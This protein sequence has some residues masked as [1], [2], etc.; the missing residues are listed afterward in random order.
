MTA[1]QSKYRLPSE[2]MMMEITPAIAGDWLETRNHPKNRKPSKTVAVRYASDM[3]GGLYRETPEPMIFDTDGLI[4]SAQHRLWAVCL[5]GTTQRFFVHPNQ[6]R[7]IFDSIDQGWKRSA[8]QVMSMPNATTVAAGARY[9]ATLDT[10]PR[11]FS[12]FTRV[13]NPEIAA[14]VKRWPS[15]TWRTSE[16]MAIR[17]NVGIPPG[18]HVAVLAQAE[19]TEYRDQ[20]DSW[21]QGLITGA[22]LS[23]GDPRHQLRERFIHRGHLL[24]GSANKDLVYSLIVK[25]WNLHV[26]G[27]RVQLLRWM[28][29]EEIPDVVGFQGSPNADATEEAA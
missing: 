1:A 19:T 26:T 6:P 10:F 20:V 14:T 17:T 21:A 18:P 3:T 9:L 7:D 25:A 8:A 12:G 22:D 13:T 24:A 16:A 15:L 4:I 27:E 11:R 29:T 28:V 23:V 5:S 2:P